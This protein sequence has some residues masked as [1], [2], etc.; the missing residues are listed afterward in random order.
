MVYDII[1]IVKYFNDCVN[2][3]IIIDNIKI[4][5]TYNNIFIIINTSYEY[6]NA[7]CLL[8][9]IET[10]NKHIHCIQS[11]KT[12]SK[13]SCLC[14]LH[15][16]NSIN[17]IKDHKFQYRYICCFNDSERFI[18]QFNVKDIKLKKYEVNVKNPISNS[19]Y[20]KKNLLKYNILLLFFDKYNI[21]P[22]VSQYNG[23]IFDKNVC[24]DILPYLIEIQQNNI[25]NTDIE[26]PIDEILY[27]TLIHFT[28]NT[29]TN[30][31]KVIWHNKFNMID[32]I[33]T[34]LNNNQYYSIK[35]S[36]KY[37]VNEHNKIIYDLQNKI[38]QKI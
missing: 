29:Y 12:E 34:T 35:F 27:P 15:L 30:I 13:F 22:I 4:F 23:L 3:N 37:N 16:Y 33:N 17:Y 38:N 32:E 24:N 1:Y 19:W 26:L 28:N 11:K 10:K 2:I 31:C 5:N 21:T 8:S 6:Y 25:L 36:N 7:N 14:G 20:H 18:K 9:D